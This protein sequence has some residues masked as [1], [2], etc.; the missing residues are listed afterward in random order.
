MVTEYR[1]TNGTVLHKHKKDENDFYVDGTSVDGK[2][3]ET[4]SRYEPVRDQ[5]GNITGFRKMNN[6]LP[7]FSG[8][9]QKLIFQYALNTKENLP[10]DLAQLLRVVKNPELQQLIA[11]TC[12]KLTKI[13]EQE[14]IRLMADIRATYKGRNRESIRQQQKAVQKSAA[15]KKRNRG[16][17]R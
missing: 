8:E 14:C 10:E 4:Q 3:T 12:E 16:E 13:P 5:D 11:G 9:E 15:G 7:T 1:L 2:Y 6:H 17:K